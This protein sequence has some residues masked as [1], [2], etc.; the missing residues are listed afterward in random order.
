MPV[1]GKLGLPTQPGSCSGSC[2]GG[3]EPVHTLGSLEEGTQARS[4]EPVYAACAALQTSD[5]QRLGAAAAAATQAGTC[6]FWPQ[7]R[8]RSLH[9]ARCVTTFEKR[10]H[11]SIRGMFL[12]VSSPA[13]APNISTHAVTFYGNVADPVTCLGEEQGTCMSLVCMFVTA[14][15]ALTGQARNLMEKAVDPANGRN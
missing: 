6:T 10:C 14:L 8:W 4:A 3:R 11:G 2:R 12:S 5:G 15:A 7:P 9:Q 1:A 13:H